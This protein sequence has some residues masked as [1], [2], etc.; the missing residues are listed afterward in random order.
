M[1]LIKFDF[2]QNKI[3]IRN[4][5][6]ERLIETSCNVSQRNFCRALNIRDFKLLL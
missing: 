3:N 2:L 6:K 5:C 1:M 4:N